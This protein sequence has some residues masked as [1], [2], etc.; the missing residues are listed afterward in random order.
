MGEPIQQNIFL[1]SGYTP[2]STALAERV[3][4]ACKK[5]DSVSI[6]EDSG[7]I[8]EKRVQ[9]AGSIVIL[10]LPNI[11]QSAIKAIRSVKEQ[12]G[13]IKI[14]A[15]H[16]YTTKLLI[17]P[18]I[19]AGANGYLNYEPSVAELR[20]AIHSVSVGERYLPGQIYR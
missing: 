2:R 16:I 10:D 8:I 14:L 1:Y 7:H 5:G 17:E 11:K 3:Q 6:I 20:E 15:I 13:D 9:L 18:L 12:S 4:K 19:E